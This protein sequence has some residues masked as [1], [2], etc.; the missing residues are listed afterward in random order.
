VEYKFNFTFD[1]YRYGNKQ[2]CYIVRCIDNKND[3]GNEDEESEV[4]PNPRMAKYNKEKNEYIKPLFELLE[5]ERKEILEL[6]SEFL[7]LSLE[8]KHFQK[9]LE[10][11]K[12]DINAMSKA[13][14][15]KK[16]QILED[17]NSSQSSQAGYDSG[18]LKKNRIE[19]IRSNLLKNISNFYTL[20]YIKIVILLIAILSLFFSIL[21]IYLFSTLNNHLKDSFTINLTLY[22]STLITCE[23]INIF[24]SFRILYHK[25]IIND[26]EDFKFYDFNAVNISELNES[27]YLYYHQH[28]EYALNLYNIE[29]S[30]SGNLEMDIPSYLTEEQLRNLYWDRVN[31]SYMN[32]C[33]YDYIDKPLKDLFPLSLAQFLSNVNSF[34]EDETFNSISEI[35]L[36]RYNENIN[37]NNL[38]FNYICHNIIE[39]GYDN[40]VPNLLHKISKIPSI[41][42][43]SNSNSKIGF[44]ILLCSYS[45]LTLI[46][47]IV[48]FFLFLITS[49]SMTKGMEKITK[50]RIEKIDEIIKKIKLFGINLKRYREKDFK[51]YKE[52]KNL[53]EISENQNYHEES[54]LE[55]KNNKN[56]KSIVQDSINNSG[57]N[58]DYKKFIPL[59]IL[60]RLI[61]PPIFILIIIVSCLLP[62]YKMTVEMINNINLLL[63]VQKYF[64][65]KLITTISLII[66]VKC[67]MSGC[68]NTKILDYSNLVDMSTIQEVIKGMNILPKISDYYNEKYLLH[69]CDAAINNKTDPISYYN[70]LIDPIVMSGNN[71]DNLIQIIENYVFF[72]EKEYEINNKTDPNY[73]QIQLFS[74][75]NFK[76]IEHIFC[77]Y[78]YPVGDIFK[79]L[80]LNE[81][82]NYLKS[83][84]FFVKFLVVMGG[85]LSVLYCLIFGIIIIKKLVNYL[86]I[87][88]CIM[89]VIPISV[90]LTTQELEA[91]IENKY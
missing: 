58:I 6:P 25:Y 62:I 65:G 8:N 12:N 85:L 40:I 17:E 33:F 13:Y 28:V 34:L 86:T 90:I 48:Y 26:Y 66:E 9:L 88:G 42:S 27:N 45:F 15:H 32:E 69:A 35:A 37:R 16:D 72:V 55:D 80:L 91:W 10:K 43:E 41:L 59:T 78:I 36:Q 63:L 30:A 75:E 38:Y 44:I 57:F 46:L 19:E 21:Y 79:E 23:I 20:K 22:E 74:S 56:K 1:K 2:I 14:G 29:Y 51:N 84:S 47:Y 31:I 50:I 18:L 64:F 73:T 52:F 77:N 39:N 60:N 5:E 3:A 24:I 76:N 11:C 54:K 70:C 67:F 71:T 89:K 82:N 49:K 61:Y 83:I 53:S 4:D 87:S 81:V 7:K 68:N